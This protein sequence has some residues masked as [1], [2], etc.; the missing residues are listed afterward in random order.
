MNW[1]RYREYKGAWRDE[2]VLVFD[3]AD[4]DDPFLKFR[5]EHYR[6]AGR[7]VRLQELHNVDTD[8]KRSV[9]CQPKFNTADSRLRQRR[10]RHPEGT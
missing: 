9:K 8:P 1:G 5:T 2:V 4:R 7:T 3:P 6:K 10:Q